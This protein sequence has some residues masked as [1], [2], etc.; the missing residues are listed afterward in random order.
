MTQPYFSVVLPIY[1]VEAYLDRCIQSILGQDEPDF[2]I[3]LVDDGSP[4]RCPQMCEEWA[5]RDSRIRVVHKQNAGLG[6]AR[7]TGI[8]NARGQYILF[9]DSD[10]YIL[11]GLLSRCRGILEEH[12]CDAVFYGYRRVKD[13]GEILRDMTPDI[14][15]RLYTRADGIDG[16]LLADFLGGNPRTGISKNLS[17]SVCICCLRMQTIRGRGLRFVSEREYISED[18]YFYLSLFPSLES[19]YLLN[20]SYYCYCQNEGSLTSSYKPDRFARQKK[21]YLDSIGEA[22]RNGLSTVVLERLTVPF[23]SN[24]MSTLKM[25]IGNIPACG[26]AEAYRN[27]KRICQDPVLR[28]VIQRYPD[29][30]LPG[31]W[32]L[33]FRCVRD[34]LYPVLFAGLFVQ[35][36]KRGV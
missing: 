10:D 33:F 34:R 30:A 32:K 22:K 5:A 29:G 9:V 17:I 2:E 26:V 35:F 16:E 19:L 23:I 7:N 4:D 12:D 6:M 31:S 1:G 24:V 27:M 21:F 14:E 15:P 20:E 18:T 13:Q 36:K 25:E 3:I 11:P 28:D 8:D